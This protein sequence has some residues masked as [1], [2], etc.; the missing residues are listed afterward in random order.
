M[1]IDLCIN[2]YATIP[3]TVFTEAL[4]TAIRTMTG[5]EVIPCDVDSDTPIEGQEIVG[6]MVLAGDKTLLMMLT[7]SKDT[8]ALLVT[9]MTGTEIESLTDSE[10]AD[11]I[12]EFVNIVGG[13]A[14][15][16]LQESNY[17]FAITVPFTV[18]GQELKVIVKK[19]ARSYFVSFNSNEFIMNFKIVEL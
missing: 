4:I 1:A 14:R 6:A 18:T 16:A 3:G 7:A 11:G 9:Y 12:T 13:S 2:N 15:A 8:A 19:S 10:L 5:F 17:R